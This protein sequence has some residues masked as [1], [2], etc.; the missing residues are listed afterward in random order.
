[1]PQ[2]NRVK[3]TTEIAGGLRYAPNLQV[4]TCLAEI[5]GVFYEIRERFEDL[6]K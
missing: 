3:I 6:E 4:G 5:V 1:M 2:A